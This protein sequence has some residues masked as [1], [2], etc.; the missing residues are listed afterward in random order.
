MVIV[1]VNGRRKVGGISQFKESN[2]CRVWEDD[3]W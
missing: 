2:K 3:G 1:D